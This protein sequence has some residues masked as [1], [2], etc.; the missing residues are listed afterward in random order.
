MARGLKRL[1]GQLL[2]ILSG[3]DLTAK[4]F[5]EYAASSRAWQGLLGD[6]KVTRVDLAEADHTF[7]Q[8]HW[9][10]R[11]IAESIAWIERLGPAAGRTATITTRH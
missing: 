5:I 3:N 1:R 2:L 8:R 6:T 10:D 4:E 7:S 9:L 11:A